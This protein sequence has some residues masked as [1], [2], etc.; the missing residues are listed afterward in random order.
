MA[1]E[2]PL[3]D[4]KK[5]D[6]WVNEHPGRPTG[7]ITK[8]VDAPVAWL[9]TL[10]GLRG[11]H[12]VLRYDMPK[13]QKLS[14][15]V[16][17]PKFERENPITIGIQHNG[18]PYIDDGNH[19]VR[20]CKLA[21]KKTYKTKIIF[22]GGGEDEFKLDDVLKKYASE[23]LMTNHEKQI[24]AMKEL[25]IKAKAAIEHG[26]D[27]TSVVAEMHKLASESGGNLGGDTDTFGSSTDQEY[28]NASD[29]GENPGGVND[30]N[31]GDQRRTGPREDDNEDDSINN[32]VQE[33]SSNKPCATCG[34]PTDAC[35]CITMEQPT[36]GKNP[37]KT[38]PG[39][40]PQ[41]DPTKSKNASFDMVVELVKHAG[42]MAREASNMQ[43]V[44]IPFSDLN[45]QAGVDYNASGKH[46]LITQLVDKYLRANVYPGNR[47]YTIARIE[48]EKN[49]LFV[50]V[51]LFDNQIEHEGAFD[52]KSGKLSKV[53]SVQSNKLQKTAWKMRL[54]EVI[55]NNDETGLVRCPIEG[56]FL[57]RACGTCPFA[58][59]PHTYIQDGGVECHFDEGPVWLNNL[60]VK[61]HRLLD[62]SS[63]G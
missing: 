13:I 5:T 9:L 32:L 41:L 6:E 28:Q 15:L 21:K 39:L 33:A 62:N 17:D 10:P 59:N 53:S 23:A 36:M 44:E 54:T 20:A 2:Y 63:N 61:E 35:V 47:R 27:Y 24:E 3:K 26:L 4:Y 50:K 56:S 14:E 37:S 16:T 42:R 40:D 19:R 29:T 43:E 60:G 30:P 8:L 38:G 49:K 1:D 55:G 22:Y 31:K 52:T 45:L 51:L 7:R 12:K 25:V 48:Q 18:K 58:G 46:Q 57:T 11:E 34:A